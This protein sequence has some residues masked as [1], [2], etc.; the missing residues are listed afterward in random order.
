MYHKVL[1]YMTKSNNFQFFG[2]AH[3]RAPAVGEI[4]DGTKTLSMMT[5]WKCAVKSV[6]VVTTERDAVC[7]KFTTCVTSQVLSLSCQTILALECI[8]LSN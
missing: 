8:V 3:M 5:D 1:L 2:H 4:R 7:S 6:S